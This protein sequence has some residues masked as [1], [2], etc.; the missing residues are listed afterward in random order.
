MSGT[1]SK[2]L[3]V[4][5]FGISSYF[6]ASFTNYASDSTHIKESIREHVRENIE[7]NDVTKQPL[8]VAVSA[9]F[10]PV[11]IKLLPEFT[12]K[13]NIKVEVISGASGALYQQI[14]H[15]APYDMFLSADDVHPN[16]LSENS[17]IVKNS[18]Q[19]Y[20]LGQLA[21]WS[22]EEIIKP[23][24]GIAYVLSQYIKNANRIALANP[25][26]APYGNRALETL[27]SLGLWQHF[28]NKVITGINVSQ[29]FQ[30]LRS[31][32]VKGGFV[33]LS[34]LKVNNLQGLTVPETLYTPI[35]QQLVILKRSNKMNAAQKLVTFLQDKNTQKVIKSYGYK[36]TPPAALTKKNIKITKTLSL[37]EH[38]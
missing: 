5:S 38:N 32:A 16:K 37:K 30:Q 4:L 33:A 27:Q 22:A 24:Q 28:K 6:L 12:H 29:T 14:I 7:K 9:N 1:M 23:K 18:L 10:S 17:L 25:N 21:F 26:T 34:Q 31:G 2:W 35:K 36:A 8:R 15:G 20:A 11:L 19:T 13:H 3:L